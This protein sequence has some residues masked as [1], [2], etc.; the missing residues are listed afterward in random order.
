MNW[1]AWAL[2]AG[3]AFAFVAAGWFAVTYG[4]VHY[5]RIP[6]GRNVM[7]MARAIAATAATGILVEFSRS[8][9]T[10]VLAALAWT[11][12]GTVLVRRHRLR[13]RAETSWRREHPDDRESQ[14]Q[15][16]CDDP[17]SC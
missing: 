3:R 10:E 16:R 15:R 5:E 17:P 8:T 14:H 1:G 11:L 7:S 6:E 4:R 2:V 13:M 12:V 9:V